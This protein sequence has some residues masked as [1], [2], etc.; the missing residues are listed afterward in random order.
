MA[1]KT[2][3]EEEQYQIMTTSPIPKLVTS[4]EMPP[5]YA[6]RYAQNGVEVICG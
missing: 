2:V 4:R 1:R 5:A 6:E 3:S